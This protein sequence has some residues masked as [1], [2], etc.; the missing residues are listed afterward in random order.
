M[1]VLELM[2][3]SFRMIRNLLYKS[4]I[5]IYS[6]PFQWNRSVARVCQACFGTSCGTNVSSVL[7]TW[8]AWHGAHD[9]TISS[10]S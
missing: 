8:C 5:R 10:M 3:V 2:F 4:A 7:A 6:V 1:I 9:F